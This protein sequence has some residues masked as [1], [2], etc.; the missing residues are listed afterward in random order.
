LKNRLKRKLSRGGTAFGV[1]IGSG[2]PN[3][4][5]ILLKYNFDWFVIDTEHSAIGPETVNH[6]LQVASGSESTPLV[7]IGQIDQYLIKLALDAGA[8]GLVAP[9]VNSKEEAER[10]VRFSRYPPQGTRG[11]AG[12]RASRYGLDFRNYLETANKEIL[13]VAQIETKEALR[14]IDEILS[15]KGIDVAF[16]G[17]TDITVSLGLRDDRTN[18]KVRVA[19]ATVVRACQKHGKTAG[20]FAI[21]KEEAQTALKMGFRFITLGSD[22]AYLKKGAMESLGSVRQKQQPDL[23]G[24]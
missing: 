10:L 23:V 14:N 8:Y 9:L 6:M 1:W 11:A 4:L 3:V 21:S 17:P 24:E 19:M 15:I 13:I 2:S 20:V 7:R 16:V 22:N 12:T 5:D 18:Q